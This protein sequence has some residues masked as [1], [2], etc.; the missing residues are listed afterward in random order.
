MQSHLCFG[1]NN[2]LL[3]EG[4]IVGRKNE[5]KKNNE[6]AIAVIQLRDDLVSDQSYGRGDGEK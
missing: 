2:W 5:D 3:F 4:Q 1:E 6:E